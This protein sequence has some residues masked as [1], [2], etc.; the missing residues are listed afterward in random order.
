MDVSKSINK[1]ELFMK[2]YKIS[3]NFKFNYS[4]LRFHVILEFK[5]LEKHF[6]YYLIELFK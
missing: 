4:N 3:R 2:S 6:I 5:G 1:E